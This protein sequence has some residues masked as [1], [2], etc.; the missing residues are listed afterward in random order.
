MRS[1]SLDLDTKDLAQLYEQVSAERQY[2]AGQR[3]I[4]D[5]AVTAGETVIDI[6]CGTGALAE[7]VASIVGPAGMVIGVDPLPLRIEIAQRRNHPNLSFRIGNAS[8]LTE[9]PP[10]TFDVV[11]MNAVFHWLPD[12]R[13]P[14]RQIVRVLKDGGRLGISTGSRDNPNPLHSL[15]ER[16]LSRAPYNR[17]P[18]AAEPVAHRVSAEEL[19]SLLTEPGFVVRSIETRPNVR[20]EMTA[21][22]A[23]RFSEASSFGNF[24]GHL[25]AELRAQAREEIRRELEST[26]ILTTSYRNRHHLVA[27]ATK[28]P[29]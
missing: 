10:Q 4:Q 24:L 13:E 3:L 18:A 15:R 1:I 14:L 21:E 23:I 20:P 2:K 17:Y 27:L 28:P 19:A 16:V 26:D 25:P 29:A 6:G 5:L 11:S 8:D 12:K 9:F 22:A 7:Y